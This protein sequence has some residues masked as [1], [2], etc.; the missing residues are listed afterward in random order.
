MKKAILVI[1]VILIELRQLFFSY[2]K[3]NLPTNI[4]KA[5][6]IRNSYSIEAPYAFVKPNGEVTGLQQWWQKKLLID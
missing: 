3:D 2:I 6:T 1:L 5:E 4:Q